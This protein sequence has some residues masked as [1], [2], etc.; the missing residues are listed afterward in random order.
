M[1]LERCALCVYNDLKA[2]LLNFFNL[3]ISCLV[4]PKIY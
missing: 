2:A 4:D 3:D 1:E